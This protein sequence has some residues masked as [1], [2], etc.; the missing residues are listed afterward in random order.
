[1]AKLNFHTLVSSASVGWWWLKLSGI[2]GDLQVA[3]SNRGG[4]SMLRPK[5]VLARD[6]FIFTWIVGPVIVL[7]EQ[8]FVL[9]RITAKVRWSIATKV[10]NADYNKG[11]IESSR[12]LLLSAIRLVIQA[13]G[14]DVVFMPSSEHLI[15]QRPF[16]QD[17]T[18]I[19]RILPGECEQSNILYPFFSQ[20]FETIVK[21]PS[22][23]YAARDSPCREDWS[24]KR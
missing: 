10:L 1:M 13:I 12:C 5:V 22:T 20:S 16:I 9:P 6:V 3:L 11:S 2:S 23:P 15:S 24:L 21:M 4:K 17:Q 14:T 18:L 19:K 7:S 8:C